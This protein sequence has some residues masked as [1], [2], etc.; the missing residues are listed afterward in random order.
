M[1]KQIAALVLA[2]LVLPGAA[3]ADDAARRAITTA[4]A[5]WTT[6]F[7]TGQ[8]DKICD[9]F[10]PELRYDFKGQPER[11]YA[12]ICRLLKKTL[13]D[14]KNRYSYQMRLKEIIDSGDLAVVRLVWTSRMV[15]LASGKETVLE[16]PGMDV[17]RRQADGSWKI[18]RYMAY[19]N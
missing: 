14:K 13:A 12:D 5:D 2:S 6:A 17:F 16:E 3:R 7:N 15:S 11:N 4:L 19:E 9:I 8:S 18:I 10:A 1:R